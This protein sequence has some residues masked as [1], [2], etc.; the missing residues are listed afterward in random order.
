MK[1]EI[2]L[3]QEFMCMF[4]IASPLPEL[5]HRLFVDLLSMELVQ[6]DILLMQLE[7]SLA[8]SC[9]QLPFQG[10]T[11]RH[12]TYNALSEWVDELIRP[13][14]HVLAGHADIL[15]RYLL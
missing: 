15:L 3:I 4:S 2:N 1:Y 8:E 10:P 12:T 7:E 11:I 5:I 6:P 9:H 13:S 14:N